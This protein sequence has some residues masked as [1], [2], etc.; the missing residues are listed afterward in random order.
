MK[1]PHE[2]KGPPDGSLEATLKAV[3]AGQFRELR[4]KIREHGVLVEVEVKPDGTV[5]DGLKRVAIARVLGLV[6]IPTTLYR[7]PDLDEDLGR[8]IINRHRSSNVLAEYKAIKRLRERMSDKE[9]ARAL[10]LHPSVVSQICRLDHLH[11]ELMRALEEGRI[12]YTVGRDAAY[13][14]RDYQERLLERLREQGQL[15]SADVKAVKQATVRLQLEAALEPPELEAPDP[16]RASVQHLVRTAQGRLSL[17][18]LLAEVEA[19]WTSA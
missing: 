14:E 9:I 19:A 1:S 8:I 13:L 7:S 2:L 16:V 6:Q 12:S 5:V 18:E 11:P 17:E 3:E 15:R 4:E 10:G